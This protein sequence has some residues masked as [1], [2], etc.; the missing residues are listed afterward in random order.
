MKQIK[1]VMVKYL[2]DPPFR[3]LTDPIPR[4][5]VKSNLITLVQTNDD[6]STLGRDG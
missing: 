3:A 5:R 2:Y 4:H 6:I 1:Q